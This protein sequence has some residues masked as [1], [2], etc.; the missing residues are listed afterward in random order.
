LGFFTPRLIGGS[1]GKTYHNYQ[2]PPI[3]LKFTC[4]TLEQEDCHEKSRQTP[5]PEKFITKRL[6]PG[7]RKA[8][9]WR[10]GPCESLPRVENTHGIYHETATPS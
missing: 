3:I 6:C 2:P 9:L 4:Y 5:L 1:Q 10:K 7:N 8:I